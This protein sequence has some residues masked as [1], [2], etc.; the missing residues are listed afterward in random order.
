MKTKRLLCLIHHRHDRSPGQRFR[1]EQFLPALQDAG[2]EIQYSNILNQKDDAVFYVSGHYFGKFRIMIKSFFHR[3]RDLKRAKKADMVFIYRE[4]FMLGSTFFE[5]RLSKIQVPVIFD[6]DDSIWLNDT[7]AGNQNL[8]WLKKPQKT[9]KI[10]Q[11]SDYVFVG[12]TYLAEYAKQFNKQVHIFPTVIDTNYHKPSSAKQNESKICIGWTGTQPTLKHFE[13]IIPTLKA[14]HERYPDK[15]CFRVIVNFPYKTNA[16]PLEVIQ[17][18]KATEIETLQ[19]FDIGIM[20]LPDDEWTR[21]KCGFKGLQY[22]ALEIPTIMSPVGVN[23]DI[24]QDGE[25]GFL[26]KNEAEWVEKISHLIESKS[27]RK[28]IGEAGRKTVVENYSKQAWKDVYIRF[29]QELSMKS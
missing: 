20:P 27:L 23:S 22:M 18:E 4:A 25:N 14:L 10:C 8:S 1:I 17:W 24:I 13:T 3:L 11:F 15:L 21:G 16:I 19:H 5:K 28:T 12:N 6:F 9:A 29:F 26:A 2:W 7:S